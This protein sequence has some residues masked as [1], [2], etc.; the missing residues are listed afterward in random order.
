MIPSQI[1][2]YAS[3]LE[4]AVE[5]FVAI[6]SWRRLFGSM[7]Y[8]KAVQDDKYLLRTKK[9]FSCP[10]RFGTKYLK[11]AESEKLQWIL[12]F[13]LEFKQLLELGDYAKFNLFSK[14]H[15]PKLV[16]K[17][18]THLGLTSSLVQAVGIVLTIERIR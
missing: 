10:L 15:H 7:V 18:A 6:G 8:I 2:N 14:L 17:S 12:I 11:V 4:F 16:L 3:Y 9:A 1:R 13:L 5:L